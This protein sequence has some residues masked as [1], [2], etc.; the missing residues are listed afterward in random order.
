M[1]H[2]R[3]RDSTLRVAFF[4]QGEGRGHMTQ[5]L[6]MKRILEASGH[7]VVA[8]FMGENPH[9]PLPP[10]VREELAGLLF[11]YPTPAFTVDRNRK[12]VLPWSTVF[13][14]IAKIPRYWAVGP[15]IHRRMR[16]TSPHLILNFYDLLGGLY[17][18]IY[19]PGIPVVAVGHQF[20]FFHPEFPTGRENWWDIQAIKWNTLLT[21]LGAR[22]RLALSFTALPDLPH[23][24][25]RVV[26]PLLRDAV[27]D[28]EPGGGNHILTYV[29]NPGYAEELDRWHRDHPEVEMHCFWDRT[30]VP[31]VTSPRKGLSFHR[32]DDRVF[33]D[34]LAG[35]R[36]YASTAGFE[37][38]CEAAFLGKPILLVPTGKHVEQ[39]CN[40]LDAARAGIARWRNDFDLSDLL[41][42]IEGFDPGPRQSFRDWV[43]GGR[44]AF[45]PLLEAVAHGVAPRWVG[46]PPTRSPEGT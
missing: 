35:C 9:R 11:T 25:I 4:V 15:E 12:G 23:R 13:R 19:R 3:G 44:E 14:A 28:A 39:R 5:A 38:V 26:P 21:A 2:R 29:L 40:A 36:G 6:A 37:S 10:F 18:F 27:L 43:K 42:E 33:L 8:V 1:T 17:V 34:L 41:D 46:L 45:L 32:L 24:R 16:E 20:L 31:A 7:Q 30:D 22:L